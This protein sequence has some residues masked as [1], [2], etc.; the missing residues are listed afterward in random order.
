MRFT[1]RCHPSG[2]HSKTGA[3]QQRPSQSQQRDGGGLYSVAAFGEDTGYGVPALPAASHV[4]PCNRAKGERAQLAGGVS[5][6]WPRPIPCVLVAACLVVLQ[7]QQ[8]AATNVRLKDGRLLKGAAAKL[9]SLVVDPQR[10]SD[11]E[12][13][14]PRLIIL[15]DDNLRRYFV[16]L[17]QVQGLDE[18]DAGEVY[19]KFRIKQRIA[20]N[21]FAVAAVG[22]FTRV[23]PWD[24]FGRR[25]VEMN[26]DR[27]TKAIIQGITEVTPHWTR[28]QSLFAAGQAI[29]WDQRIATATIP[30]DKLSQMLGKQIERTN[31]DQRLR[32]VRFYLQAKRFKDARDE[33]EEVI[34]D[35]PERETQ[36]SNVVRDLTQAQA[37]ELVAEIRFRQDAGQHRLAFSMLEHFPTEGVAGETLQTVRRMLDEYQQEYEEYQR[38]LSTFDELLQKISD[39]RLREQIAPIR[40]EIVNE[41]N[42]NT[43]SRMAAYL[44][45]VDDEELP[46]EDRLALGISGWLV[47]TNDATRKLPV[48]IS[49]YEVRNLVRSYLVADRNKAERMQI[50]EALRS[51]EGATPEMVAKLL[52]HLRPPVPRPDELEGE[53]GLYEL[54]APGAP[55][56]GDVTYYVQ[57]PHEYDDHRRYPCIITLHAGFTT[58]REQIDWWAGE[59]MEDGMRRG[60]AYRQGYIVLAPAWGEPHQVAYRFSAAETAAVLNSLRHACRRF[61]IDTDRVFL[62]GHSMGGDAAW[63]IGLAHPDLWA[64]VIPIAAA[65]DKFVA[66]YWQNA[67]YL[68][69]YFVC[70]E[71]DGDK[72][73]RNARDFDRYLQRA[74]D[75]TVCEFQGRGHELFPDELLSLFDWMGRRHRNFFPREF[76][77]RSMRSWDNFFWWA[78]LEDMAPSTLVDPESWPPPRGTKEAQIKGSITNGNGIQLTASAARAILWLSPELVDFGQHVSITFNGRR[79]RAIEDAIR[80]DI[81]V[82][83]EDARTRADRL[84]PFWAK[85]EVPTGR[86]NNVALRGRAKQD[87]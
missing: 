51:Q 15:V 43:L 64:G 7:V 58:A 85:V 21:G 79:Q 6:S 26:T 83:L 9:E 19:E 57:V 87:R 27:G 66:R 13:P 25:T 12:A 39:T 82:M 10:L 3:A 32:L 44:Q 67:R 81:G 48:A 69:W 4:G 34:R 70:G 73:V 54:T 40:E 35:F 50:L 86:V 38:V 28:V 76:A 33:L 60:Q 29:V 30:R 49:L 20:R 11:D 61:A 53:P 22:A 17:G 80:P 77:C 8:A 74:F 31:L 68:P 52:A 24:E 46:L 2:C 78:E 1:G 16:P 5:S 14:V 42:V 23:E 71:L 36:F 56:Q 65:S 62:T 59:R 45:F 37:R 63:D 75:V 84:H 41:L 55:G 72:H 47:G 18:G